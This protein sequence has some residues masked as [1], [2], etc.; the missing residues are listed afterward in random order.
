[1]LYIIVFYDLQILGFAGFF[2]HPQ[3]DI[4]DPAGWDAWIKQYDFE[5][6]GQT[7]LNRFVLSNWLFLS[8]FSRLSI[9]FSSLRL[10]SSF[11]ETRKTS[12]Q[13]FQ[14]AMFM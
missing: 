2:D 1:M 5:I 12:F 13:G 7:P 11:T 3:I 4:C 14:Q 10:C 9:R 6:S 8:Y